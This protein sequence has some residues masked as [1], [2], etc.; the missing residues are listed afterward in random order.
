M[1]LKLSLRKWF[2]QIDKLIIICL[3]FLELLGNFTILKISYTMSSR[4]KTSYDLIF[5][6]KH[7]TFTG[8]SIFLIFVFSYLPWKRTKKICNFLFFVFLF[9]NFL[10]IIIGSKSNGTRRWIHLG[11]L[12]SLQSSEF[13]KTLIVF[14]VADFLSKGKHKQN[15]ILIGISV[16]SCLLQPDLG[17]T[18]LILSSSSSLIFLKGENLKQYASIV[19]F[20]LIGLFISGVFLAKY[21][22]NR[23]MI[24]FGKKSGFQIIQSLKSFSEASLIGETQN[25]IYIPDSH[26]DFMF[27]EL[28]S[29]FGIIIGIIVILIPMILMFHINDKNKKY[30]DC[31]K[32]ISNGIVLQL[33]VQTYFHVLSN[34]AFVPTKGL[35]LPFVSFGGSSILAYS[36]SFGALLSLTKRFLKF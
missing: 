10:T 12:F 4:F 30:S 18:F 28:V 13:V 21:A 11:G 20:S 22:L 35:N 14:P 3:G 33:A 15:L 34:L 19:M 36:L 7:F 1:D 32:L 5:F 31:D 16:L 6:F 8:I 25:N 23:I 29:S 9:L 27:A 24:F 26:C 17:M 2:W